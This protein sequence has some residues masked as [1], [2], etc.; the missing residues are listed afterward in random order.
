MITWLVSTKRR[1]HSILDYIVTNA[2]RRCSLPSV[3]RT[4]RWDEILAHT[5]TPYKRTNTH[6]YSARQDINAV[7]K[8]TAIRI[9][10]VTCPFIVELQF[11]D[12]GKSRCLSLH[13]I[14]QRVAI[15]SFTKIALTRRWHSATLLDILAWRIVLCDFTQLRILFATRGVTLLETLIGT[16]FFSFLHY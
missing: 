14:L 5:Y 11:R 3:K 1:H 10:V 8:H 6:S 16:I 4:R 7:A 15:F 9:T 12:R 13:M 2:F